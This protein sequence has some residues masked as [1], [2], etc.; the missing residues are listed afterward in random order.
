MIVDHGIKEIREVT[1]YYERGS[2]PEGHEGSCMVFIYKF[3]R[4]GNI[5]EEGLARVAT[6]YGFVYDSNKKMTD[7]T[8]EDEEVTHF[9]EVLKDKPA[10]FT[11]GLDERQ[12][13]FDKMLAKKSDYRLS[14]EDNIVDA[15][16]SID[17]NYRVTLTS[18]KGS[19]PISF[20]ATKVREIERLF[21]KSHSSPKELYFYY[22]YELFK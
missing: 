9:S 6:T 22:D 19:L 8:W 4:D 20:K 16:F 13:R 7:W 12:A 2:E 17:A 10:D 5:L 3:D 15:C 11:S 14:Y 1:S 18:E 21:K